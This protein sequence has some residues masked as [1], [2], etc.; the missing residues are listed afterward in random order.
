MSDVSSAHKDPDDD[1]QSG[2]ALAVAMS[3]VRLLFWEAKVIVVTDL[4]KLLVSGSV[5]TVF[6][7]IAQLTFHRAPIDAAGRSVLFGFILA[8]LS[9]VSAYMALLSPQPE[10][11]GVLH[12]KLL[13]TLIGVVT[14]SLILFA[15]FCLVCGGDAVQAIYEFIAGFELNKGLSV[16]LSM[17]PFGFFAVILIAMISERAQPITASRLRKLIGWSLFYIALAAVVLKYAVVDR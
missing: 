12:S 7:G 17:T 1:I 2:S 11:V 10:P 9:Y 15:L 16:W 3:A 13:Q 8:I 5:G 4:A 6:I 14:T